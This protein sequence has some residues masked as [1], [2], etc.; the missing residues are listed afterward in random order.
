MT[1]IEVIQQARQPEEMHILEA[2]V[3]RL[4]KEIDTSAVQQGIY[5][6]QLREQGANLLHQLTWNA[7][8]GD[9]LKVPYKTASRR[10]RASEWHTVLG[11]ELAAL[12]F[13][14]YTNLDT[15]RDLPADIPTEEIQS[16]FDAYR[17]H[18]GDDAGELTHKWVLRESRERAREI[19]ERMLDGASM[20]DI[21][22][23]YNCT[24]FSNQHK[25]FVMVQCPRCNHDFEWG[26][27]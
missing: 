15:L 2:H 22:E 23:L 9:I 5:L 13:F 19:V 17:E 12:E 8:C 7:Y 4:E 16:V 3:Q 6:K 20:Q 26:H 1:G 27:P 14:P 24:V 10:I 11:V 18:V 21:I 25:N